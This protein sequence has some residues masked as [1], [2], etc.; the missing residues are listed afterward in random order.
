MKRESAALRK[1]GDAHF[2]GIRDWDVKLIHAE[3]P[4]FVLMEAT[5]LRDK[6]QASIEGL[7]ANP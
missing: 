3:N 1:A 7:A 4:Y 2:K 5:P 6:A